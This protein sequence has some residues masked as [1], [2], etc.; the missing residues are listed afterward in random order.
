MTTLA[1][2]PA[3]KPTTNHTRRPPGFRETP[4]TNVASVIDLFSFPYSLCHSFSDH[5]LRCSFGTERYQLTRV[6][7]HFF[8]YLPCIYKG[9]CNQTLLLK[10]VNNK[11]VKHLLI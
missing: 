8:M 1:R 11:N 5:E 10:Q 9:K 2:K 4:N 7:C 3:I 6:D